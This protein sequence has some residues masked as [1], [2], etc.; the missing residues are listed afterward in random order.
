[1]IRLTAYI[2]LALTI[3]LSA[4]W[5]AS[6]SGQVSIVWQEWE[7]RFS[8]AVL[9]SL[10]IIY[11]AFLW[12]SV[13]IIRKLN[14]FTYFSN[15]KRLAARRAKG[16]KNL[17]QAWSSY[18]LGDYKKSIKFGLRARSTLGEGGDVLRLLASATRKQ[19]NDENPYLDQLKS[20]LVS[21]PWVLTQEL[22]R[23]LKK[24]A[25]PSAMLLVQAM[26]KSYPRNRLL[27]TLN[28]SLSAQLGNWQ[29]AK[30]GLG[31]V[32]K[33][34]GTLKPAEQ[35]HLSAVIDYCLALEEKAAGNKHECIS[36]LK[37]A[38]KSSPSF[39]PAAQL[40]A[41]VY[42]DQGDQKSAEKFLINIWKKSPNSEIAD[43]LTNLFPLEI[44]GERFKRLKAISMSGSKFSEN[45]H[46]LADQA[47][48]MEQWPDARSALQA[49]IG[50]G[51]A[52]KKTY[53]S[54]ALLE[55]KQK[56]DKQA[57]NKL[58]KKSEIAPPDNHWFCS[59]CRTA[60]AHY[61]AVCQKCDTFDKIIWFR[62]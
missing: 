59:S 33:E 8:V 10:L 29:A 30:E 38:L 46:L 9:I 11:T 23:S 58:I 20:S 5:F 17:D 24:Q 61:T 31:R 15:P 44:K 35:K 32:I 50:S 36:L 43:L 60:P 21:A 3:A 4:S 39:A 57:S 40:G 37:S 2:L 56:N 49:V 42:I 53:Q 25:W 41:R 55:R 27:L 48:L 6:N 1:M 14:I 47:I 62:L 45:Y 13:W 18:A 12:L 54:L 34:K 16:E 22:D 51:Q 7:V 52:S 19:S 26:L 28:V